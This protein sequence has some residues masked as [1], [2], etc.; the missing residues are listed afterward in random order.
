[1]NN[2]FDFLDFQLNQQ[3]QWSHEFNPYFVPLHFHSDVK[4]ENSDLIGGESNGDTHLVDV[5]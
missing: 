4:T 5:V 2:E 3:I 1:V